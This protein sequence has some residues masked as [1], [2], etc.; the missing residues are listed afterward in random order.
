LCHRRFFVNLDEFSSEDFNFNGFSNRS[1]K[2]ET[3]IVPPAEILLKKWLEI[4][5]F[6]G[7]PVFTRFLPSN[8]RA[9]MPLAGALEGIGG[10]PPI[11]GQEW[12]HWVLIS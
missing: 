4:V 2:N 9:S 12:S 3:N 7:F 1:P 6:E 10:R 5:Y 11:G 8:W